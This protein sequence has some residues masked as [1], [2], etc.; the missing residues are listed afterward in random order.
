MSALLDGMSVTQNPLKC[1]LTC[2]QSHTSIFKISHR[3]LYSAMFDFEGL[4]GL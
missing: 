3:I 2:L 4:H 1:C